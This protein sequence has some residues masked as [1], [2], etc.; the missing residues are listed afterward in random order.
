MTI[1]AYCQYDSMPKPTLIE[2]IISEGIINGFNRILTRISTS[3]EIV[4]ELEITFEK[5]H[6]D[7]T[8]FIVPKEE[9]SNSSLHLDDVY[10][11]ADPL[12]AIKS[13]QMSSDDEINR[14]EPSEKTTDVCMDIAAVYIKVSSRVL[15]MS[16]ANDW[17][18]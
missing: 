1:S 10:T 5:D 8:K 16:C 14:L 13:E 18:K 9:L 7:N 4:E 15:V 12:R 17:N 11:E 3:K 2:F 6:K